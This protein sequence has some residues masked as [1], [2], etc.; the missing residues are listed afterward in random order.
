MQIFYTVR[1]GDTLSGIAKRWEIPLESLIA[2][3][4]LTPPYTIYIGQQLSIPPGVDVIRVKSGDTVYRIAQLFRIPQDVII[5][6]NQLILPYTIETGQLLKVPPGVPYYVIQPG[7]TLFQI[8]K[9]YN[10]M[11]AGQVN[12]ELIRLVN[13]LSSSTIFPGMRLTIP[14]AP[15]GSPG[16]IAY[17]ANRGGEYDIWLYDPVTGGNVRMTTGLGES[18]SIP[19]WSPDSS[20]IA[21]VGK[22]AVLYILTVSDGE[23]ARI[24]QFEEGLGIFLDWSPDSQKLVYPKQNGIIL[25]HVLTHG[26]ER[27]NEQGVSDVQWFPNGRELLYQASDSSGIS[28]LFRIGTDGTGKRQITKNS[29][30]RLNEVRLS[31]DGLFALYTTPGASISLIYTVNL[32][33]GNVYEVK[34]G[35]LAKNYFPEWSPNSTLIAY[36]A[37]AFDDRGYFSLIRTSGRQGENELTWAISN[38]FS[39]PVTWSLD[40]SK[41]AYLSGCTTGG[42]SSEMW[43][44]D[45]QHPV[46]IKLVEDAF[47]SSLKWSPTS[48]TLL[49]KT[50]RNSLYRVVFRYPPHWQRVTDE[51]YE[52]QDGFFQISAIFSEESIHEICDNEAFHPLMPYGS[53]PRII[54]TRI[55]NQEACMIFPSADQPPEMRSQAA[56]IV[57]YPTPVTI[58]G[59]VYNY[60]ILWADQDYLDEISSTFAFL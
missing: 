1:Q 17:L 58:Q 37:T 5:E 48:F 34:G 22:N 28:Q 9:R 33:T 8:A 53:S 56:M 50:Y 25:Y 41:I 51:R 26:A 59:T 14:Y 55:Q 54:P 32:G 39:T 27:I 3:N 10:V 44:I 46:P 52:G 23:V 57:K 45:L 11:T 18:Y 35:P 16:F 38:C 19:F 60:F 12:H 13:G 31:P 29:G 49:R 30:G 24:D 2:A 43:M 36:S 42:A 15:P 40:S 21:F 7:D 47:I 4:N 20:R 6:A